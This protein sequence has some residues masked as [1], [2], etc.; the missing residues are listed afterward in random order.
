VRVIY[1]GGFQFPNGDAAAARVLGMG[2]ALRGSG[3]DVVFAGS[4]SS[5][6]PQDVQADG[7]FAYQSFPYF[8]QSEGRSQGSN[9]IRRAGLYLG[10]GR[11]TVRFLE[12]QDACGVAAVFVYQT[13]ATTMMRVRNS[14]ARRGIPVVADVTEWYTPEQLPNGRFGLPYWDSEFRLRVFV[15]RYM[16]HVVCISSYLG[17]YFRS[18]GCHTIEV[19]PLID[20]DEDKWRTDGIRRD[21]V[22]PLRLIYAGTPGK[23]DLIGNVVRAVSSLRLRGREVVLHCVGPTVQEIAAVDANAGTLVNDNPDAFIFHGRLPQ[24]SV[25]ALLSNADFSVLVRPQARYAQAGFPT[26]LVESLAASVPVIANDTGDIGRFVSDGREGIILANCS[27]Q[28]VVGGIER[29]L[30]AGRQRWSEMRICA[31]ERGMGSFD[32]QAHSKR[33]GEFMEEIRTVSAGA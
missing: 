4:E 24:H 5:G 17:A 12:S 13:Y 3:Y 15:P 25:P 7:S 21:G 9:L 1:V 32:Y 11:R 6:R 28:A 30:V 8:P 29:L 18:K 16:R 20:P 26:K 2:K 33:I 14:C 31:R 22:Q 19:P 10:G 27:V 23:K